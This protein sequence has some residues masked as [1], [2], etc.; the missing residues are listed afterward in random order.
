MREQRSRAVKF[1]KEVGNLFGDSRQERSL[2]E[3]TPE[4]GARRIAV[5]ADEMARRSSHGVAKLRALVMLFASL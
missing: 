2:S 3:M 4:A 5:A 1:R